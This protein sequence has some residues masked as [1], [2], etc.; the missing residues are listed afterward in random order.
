M[1]LRAGT[2]S[3]SVLFSLLLRLLHLCPWIVSRGFDV[4]FGMGG[5]LDS[6]VLVTVTLGLPLFGVQHSVSLNG[7]WV[8]IRLTFLVPG[9][10]L[11]TGML[12]ILPLKCLSEIKCC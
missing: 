10:L 5:C 9:L 7:A 12:M 4:Y 2:C 3:E 6:V 11:N 8:L 1:L